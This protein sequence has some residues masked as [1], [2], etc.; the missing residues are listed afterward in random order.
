M[1]G[2]N[3]LLAIAALFS[4]LVL[5]AA[6][7]GR[8]QRG[9]T[10]ED[11][12]TSS[13]VAGPSGASGV[14]EALP[15]VGVEARRLRDRPR[16][17]TRDT[18]RGRDALLVLAPVMPLS[19]EET[20]SLLEYNA[21]AG[22][23]EL[24]LAGVTTAQPMRCFGYRVRSL[25]ATAGPDSAAA[26]IGTG[27][28]GRP[29]FARASLVRAP[30]PRPDSVRSPFGAPRPSCTLVPTR[31]VDTLLATARGPVALRL[32]RATGG[33]DVILVADPGLFAN[34]QLRETRAGPFVL[35]LLARRYDRVTFDEY[36]QGFGPSGSLAR[37]L[38]S[39][40]LRSP[41]GWG[42]WQAALA[43]TLALIVTGVRFGPPRALTER[44]RRASLE[45]VR[46]LATALAAARGHDVAI[47]SLVQGL[48]RRL[49]PGA[50]RTRE[51]ARTWLA[52]LEQQ[53]MPPPA[54]AALRELET[55]AA[56]GQNEEAVL[57]AANDVEDVWDTLR[58]STPANWRR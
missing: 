16:S 58:Q 11:R 8:S 22:G 38:F 4:A 45:H 6:L 46:A 18:A 19:N 55:L 21:R 41:L 10:D 40:S 37:A 54:R 23:G 57:R 34:R 13:F 43:G 31:R 26:F 2:R 28:A 53:T 44:K 14:Y 17:L 52:S 35:S 27:S 7:L 12:R 15:A 33:H 1:R 49:S 24:V 48:R 20:R 36:H 30:P 32:E 42:V 3:G 9:T 5:A 50:R 39:W 47:D 25:A 29:F 51:S 56:P